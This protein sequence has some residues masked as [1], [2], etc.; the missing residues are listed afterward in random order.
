[1]APQA[2]AFD[3]EL[4][5]VSGIL[6]KLGFVLDEDQPHISGERFLMMRD[7]F[8]LMG[9]RFSDEKKVV[10]KASNLDLG[11]SEIVNEKK[12]RDVL[13]KVSFSRETILIPKEI[14]YGEHDGYLF[15][16]TEFIKQESVFPSFPL[17]V[18]FFLI[19]GTLELME[20]F[21]APSHENLN[22]IKGSLPVL[23]AREYFKNFTEFVE[24][25]KN[26]KE[27]PSVY[28]SMQE[29]DKMLWD[30]KEI[31][32]IYCNYL[33][34]TDLAPGN[35]KVSENNLYLLDLSSMQFGN[36][37]E[38]WARF[39]N[40]AILHSPELEET[41]DKYVK[42][43]FK[44]EYQS[45]RMMRIYKAGLLIDYYIRSI[46]KTEG[47]LKKLTEKRIELWHKVLRSLMENKPMPKDYLVSYK[48]E[49]NELRSKDEL[50]RQKEFNLI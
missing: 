22:L 1:M 18:Q 5:L 38:G 37:Y 26:Y 29:A 8:V 41:L 25:S 6:E 13:S 21:H 2:I 49:R 45:L 50:E 14:Y 24:R 46:E 40:W 48:T 33:T 7:K 17:D 28:Q 42:D 10:I 16:I 15:S 32:D 43:N 44:E 19:L 9:K 30:N 3:Q 27:D 12:A 47:D 34:H 35:F 39:L 11:K 20:G 4:K 36:K 23:Y 31:I